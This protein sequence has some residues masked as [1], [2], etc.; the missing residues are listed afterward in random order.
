MRLT[1]LPL[2][3]LFAIAA[4]GG[5]ED[6]PSTPLAEN[7]ESI[8]LRDDML[9]VEN[10]ENL[11][12]TLSLD[13]GNT[14]NFYEPSVGG[15]LITEEG[16][17]SNTSVMATHDIESKS[18]VEIYQAFAPGR[19]VPAALTDAQDRLATD[20]ARED[21]TAAEPFANHDDVATRN[22]ANQDNGKAYDDA[23]NKTQTTGPCRH[24]DTELCYGDRANYVFA[25]CVRRFRSTSFTYPGT[26][27]MRTTTCSTKGTIVSQIA[28]KGSGPAKVVRTTRVKPGRREHLYWRKPSNSRTHF[29]A[30]HRLR[31][32][33]GADYWARTVANKRN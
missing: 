33:R 14:L 31:A 21:M 18:V 11:L 20:V 32:P 3:S 30:T 24:F 1:I 5:T 13:N 29:T 27:E 19:P 26:K 12:A 4:C 16:L 28:V 17:A 10:E 23:I 22:D 7:T 9:A 2:C 6:D 8:Q 15:V 25:R